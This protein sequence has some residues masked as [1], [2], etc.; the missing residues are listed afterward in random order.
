MGSSRL[1][2]KVLL[3]LAGRPVLSWICRAAG[4]IT[5]VDA[6]VVA[7]STAPGD[8]PIVAW[9]AA[10]G[11]TSHRGPEADV[12]ERF[13][14][15]AEAEG[16]GIVIRLTAD[17]PFLDPAVASSVVWLRGAASADY[18]SNVDPPGFPDGLDCEVFTYEALCAAAKDAQRPTDREHVTPF[19]RNGRRRFRVVSLPGP[20]P[21]LTEERWTLDTSK[22]L[23]F[24]Q[25]VA[26]KLPATRPP[27][28]TE[29][30]AVLAANPALRS[31]NAGQGHNEG[32]RRSLAEEA[33]K[34][35]P[36]RFST[37][38]AMFQRVSTR[39][40]LATQTF[41]R[42]HMQ[43]PGGAAP[44]FL[45]HGHGGRVWDVDGNEYVDMMSSLLSAVLGYRD[46]DVDHAVRTQL[47]R[48]VTLSL[49][50]ELEY[51]L[52]EK[53]AEI[54]PSAEMTRFG[55]NGTDATSAAI[56]IARAATRR[57]HVLVSGYHGWQDWYIGQTTRN[58]GVPAAVGALTHGFP[59][60]DLD[61][62][63]A[64]F[65]RFPGEV[66]A[67]ILE[68]MAATEPAPGFLEGVR[69]ITHRN[70]AI[71]VFDEIITGFRF[72]LGGAQSYF[73]VTPDLSCF[74]KAAA[75]GLPLAMITGKA[76]LMAEMTEVFL[77]STFGGEA[78][79]LAAAIA[80]IDKMRREPVIEK[81]WRTGQALADGANERFR[82]HGLTDVMSLSGKAP[83]MV[84]GFRDHPAA[85]KEAIKTLFLREMIQAGVLITA[86]HNVNYA[87]DDADVATVLAA[88]DR[89][90]PVLAGELARGG[91][92]ERLDCGVIEPVFRVR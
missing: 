30:L 73:G 16:A 84:L 1:P 27:A 10:N 78:L 90:L 82:Q 44:L 29:V 92:E 41:S 17:C 12:L 76:S 87:H 13:R 19:I 34:P 88:Y 49:A 21:G 61:A 8:D 77:S 20:G 24:L 85:R 81:L 7:T 75:N 83:W 66:A 74:G 69:D 67:V 86:S 15:A 23:A 80:T 22:D 32:Y 3:D 39:V 45:T 35:V 4:A 59:F 50:T 58:K 47:T 9:C 37:S 71:L 31:L 40:P 68:P 52:A 51:D 56:R 60:N 54:I 65:K 14:G 42:S 28:W 63:N 38:Q 36:R 55:K 43:L 64:L 89:A 6:V 25:A 18:A 79:S 72:A 26:A 57:D 5:G 46:P 48:G 53:L 33:A 62:L 91:L 11:I 2:G 70:G